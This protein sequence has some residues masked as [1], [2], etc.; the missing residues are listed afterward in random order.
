MN[1][2]KNCIYFRAMPREAINPF[3]PTCHHPAAK[4]KAWDYLVFGDYT[5]KACNT[6]RASASLCGETGELFQTS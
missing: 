4:E 2:C 1:F 3:P 6:M 5:H